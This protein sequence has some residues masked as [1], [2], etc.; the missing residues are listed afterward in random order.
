MSPYFTH[1]PSCVVFN[2]DWMPLFGYRI[3]LK[4]PRR[5]SRPSSMNVLVWNSGWML[6]KTV[7]LPSV[8]SSSNSARKSRYIV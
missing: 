8:S 5:V 7:V 6:L 4:R 2:I 1:D 3:A